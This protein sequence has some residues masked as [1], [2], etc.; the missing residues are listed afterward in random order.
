M[1]RMY[2][3][4]WPWKLRPF[5]CEYCR[6]GYYQKQKLLSHLNTDRHRDAIVDVMKGELTKFVATDW[7]T[8]Y[9]NV[10]VQGSTMTAE[11][12]LLLQNKKVTTADD[13]V[14]SAVNTYQYN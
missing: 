7:R 2:V 9:L 3:A 5:L 8:T 11:H 10:C 1:Q 13:V 6:N 4:H 14:Y 12:L